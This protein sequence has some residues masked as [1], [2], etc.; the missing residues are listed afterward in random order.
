[1][2]YDEFLISVTTEFSLGVAILL[3]VCLSIQGRFNALSTVSLFL[4]STTRIF[5]TRSLAS[6]DTASYSFP[7][8]ENS[9]FS[10][11]LKISALVFPKIGGYPTN[12]LPFS[13]IICKSYLGLINTQ[14][15]TILLIPTEKLNSELM[16]YTILRI[17]PS[18]V[19]LLI[20]YIKIMFIEYKCFL[21][22]NN[23]YR[24][25]MLIKS[26]EKIVNT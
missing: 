5:L 22:N 9:A 21:N 12:D 3:V 1:L 23:T 20:F 24:I 18:V 26:F 8:R 15:S 2:S 16:F 13:I 25:Q 14:L 4:L 10:I 19:V 11:L 7:A 6:S 17:L